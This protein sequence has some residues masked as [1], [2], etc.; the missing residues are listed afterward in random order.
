[1]KYFEKQEEPTVILLFGD[2]Q[3]TLED[4]FYDKLY[5]SSNTD[6]LEETQ[7]KYKTPYVLWANYDIPE[8]TKDLSANQLGVLVKQAAGIPLTSYDCFLADFSSKIPILNCNG[9]QDTDGN[10]WSLK[11]YPNEEYQ[12]LITNYSY[13]QYRRYCEWDK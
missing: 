3:P 9:Y 1:V 2:H 7:K 8:E 6:T 12:Q 10:W 13:V 11:E 4:E 5:G